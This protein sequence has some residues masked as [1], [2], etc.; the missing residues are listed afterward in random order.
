MLELSTV[1]WAQVV[2]GRFL[3]DWIKHI[4]RRMVLLMQEGRTESRSATRE[5]KVEPGRVTGKRDG[6]IGAELGLKKRGASAGVRV[7]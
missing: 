5:M 7:G 3:R 4:L 6:I 1:R 2:C